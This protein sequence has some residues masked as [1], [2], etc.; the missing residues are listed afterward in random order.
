M[1]NSINETGVSICVLTYKQSWEK[2]KRTLDSIICQKEVDFEIVISD[3]GS[4]ENHSEEVRNYFQDKQY[5]DYTFIS[6]ERNTGTVQNFIR[7]AK[8]CKK[9]YVKMIGPGDCILEEDT[10]CRWLEF[11]TKSGK[12]WSFSDV[13]PYR[14]EGGAIRKV[15]AEEHPR[16]KEEYRKCDDEL[17]RWNYVVLNDIA[18]GAAMMIEKD[19]LCEY[20][21]KIDGR[22][23]YAED[24]IYRL[25]MYDGVVGVYYPESAVLY[26]YGCGVS[27][28]NNKKWDELISKDWNETNRMMAETY[29]ADDLIHRRVMNA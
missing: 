29:N 4:E 20:L 18:V 22:L 17:S 3:D 6:S 12:R 7:A 13:E 23:V 1:K 25:M 28:S 19:L 21:S 27:T 26:E 2:L 11:L 15:D 8:V 10:L 5:I 16:L 24:N 14:N 9:P